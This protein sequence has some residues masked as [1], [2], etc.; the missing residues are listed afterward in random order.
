VGLRRTYRIL[1]PEALL[2]M[3][4]DRVIFEPYGLAGGEPG[5]RSR[6]FIE[7]GN[8]REPLP[9]KVTMTVPHNAVIIHEQAGAGGFGPAM[10]RDPKLVLEDLLD[11]KISE[12]Y[13]QRHH[14]VSLDGT[15]KS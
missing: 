8:S 5:G 3:R 7:T 2:Q 1:A 12:A 6:N 13:A 9:G 10:A 11:G 14:G 4:T 15:A